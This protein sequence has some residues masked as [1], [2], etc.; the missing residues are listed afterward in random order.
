MNT[1]GNDIRI[2]LWGGS[3]GSHIG[4]VLEGVKGGLELDN[5]KITEEMSLRRPSPGIGTARMEKDE[6]LFLSGVTEGVT[7]GD[8]I[9]IMIANNDTRS[10]DYEQFRHRPR[11]GH[12]DFT[13]VI[14]NPNHDIR[15]GGMFSGRLT[16]PLVA[17]GT[18]CRLG[19]EAEGI[20]I[21]A[22]T[23]GI[24]E[25]IDPQER[26]IEECWDSRAFSSRACTKDLDDEMIETIMN[27]SSEGDSLGG[28]VE[29][30]LENLPIGVGE[31]WFDSLDGELAKSMFSIPAMRAFEIGD[32][33]LSSRSKGSEM[34]DPFTLAGNEVFTTTNHHGG[35]LGGRSSGMPLVFRC[36]LKPTP[37]ISKTQC[38]VDLESLQDVQLQI[39]GRH[40]PCI[41]PRAVAVVEA[42]A[43]H[44][45]YDMMSRGGFLEN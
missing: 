9:S 43:C 31:P 4:C 41:V 33:L 18:V 28:V 39:E 23:R 37:S 27:A 36:F 11:P 13:A 26:S 45:I 14:R 2:T 8:P 24:G 42:M 10:K 19:L 15:G 32:G 38:T 17:A 30:H 21:G 12:A 3:H 29:C 6:V 16:A 35:V 1:I 44:C 5:D 40:D 7:N 20:D 22:F 34:N 25:V